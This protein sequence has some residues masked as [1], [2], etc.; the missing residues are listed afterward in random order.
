MERDVLMPLINEYMEL[1]QWERS[2]LLPCTT[3]RGFNEIETGN[4][5]HIKK[6]PYKVPFALRDETR[7]ELDEMLQR[8][9][10]YPRILGM[11]SAR[12]FGE[13]EISG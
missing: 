3:N 4:A 7:K 1:F 9:V 11:G 13:D 6:N 12:N 2:G 5:L 10:I 8:G